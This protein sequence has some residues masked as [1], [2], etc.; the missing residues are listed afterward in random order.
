[1]S[2]RATPFTLARL[3]LA[4][5][6]SVVALFGAGSVLYGAHRLFLWYYANEMRGIQIGLASSCGGAEHVVNGDLFEGETLC[7]KPINAVP[8]TELYR[9]HWDTALAYY[10]IG[11]FVILLIGLVVFYLQRSHAPV[12]PFGEAPAA[13][14]PQDSEHL[15]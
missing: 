9:R 13:P 7:N 12:A 11:L 15:R 14:S 1:M 4:I 3:G 6:Q 5:V 10:G 2:E 8:W